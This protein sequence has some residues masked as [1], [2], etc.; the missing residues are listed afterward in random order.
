METPSSEVLVVVVLLICLEQLKSCDNF[1][2][3]TVAMA[4]DD[5]AG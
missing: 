4:I 3:I 1:W 2:L 5:L